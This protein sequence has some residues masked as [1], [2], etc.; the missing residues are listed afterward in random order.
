[1]A[2][3]DSSSKSIG[4]LVGITVVGA[5]FVVGTALL[6]NRT[7]D[8]VLPTKPYSEPES[9]VVFEAPTEWTVGMGTS[10]ILQVRGNRIEKI[11]TQR[12]TCSNFSQNASNKLEQTLKTKPADAVALWEQEFPGLTYATILPSQSGSPTLVGVDTCSSSV[13]RHI[14]TFRGQVYHNEI[15]VRFTS[16]YVLTDELSQAQL[17]DVA[18]SLGKGSSTLRQ[19]EFSAFRSVLSSVR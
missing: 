13:N 14:L 11:Q 12:G 3:T 10:N 2:I 6:K 19:A 18:K 17:D 5:I 1:M 7:R 16:E 15:E 9:G 4:L 8:V